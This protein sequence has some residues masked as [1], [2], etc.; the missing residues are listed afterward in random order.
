MSLHDDLA[1]LKAAKAQPKRC[2]LGAEID[3]MSPEDRD[4]IRYAITQVGQMFNLA[5]IHEL[6]NKNG[7]AMG[8]TVVS[9][10]INERCSCD[11]S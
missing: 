10:H 2:K 1:A 4:A 5:E 9:D 7:F 3:R 11:R 6:L 8:R